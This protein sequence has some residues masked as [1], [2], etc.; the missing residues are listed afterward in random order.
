MSKTLG[1]IDD[2]RFSI[3]AADKMLA[4]NRSFTLFEN[5]FD[6]G[7]PASYRPRNR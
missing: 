2:V 4:A 1:E 6:T 5:Q 3:M 7:I